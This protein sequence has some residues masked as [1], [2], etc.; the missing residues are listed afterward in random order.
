M[1]GLD[2]CASCRRRV[3]MG[4]GESKVT[5][6]RKLCSAHKSSLAT[7]AGTETYTTHLCCQS[8]DDIGGTHP[9]FVR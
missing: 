8:C 3:A 7:V 1:A 6:L 4:C 9:W 2:D 5:R